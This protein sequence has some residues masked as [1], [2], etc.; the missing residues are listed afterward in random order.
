[1]DARA[2]LVIGCFRAG[3][4]DR[5]LFGF[6]LQ[7]VFLDAWQFDDRQ[8]VV[9]LLEHIDRRKWSPAGRRVAEPLTRQVRIKRPL[10]VEQWVEWIG[11]RGDH[12]RTL[13]AVG[14][15]R[16]FAPNGTGHRPSAERFGIRFGSVKWGVPGKNDTRPDVGKLLPGKRFIGLG[17]REGAHSLPQFPSSIGLRQERAGVDSVCIPSAAGRP[18]VYR[19]GVPGRAWLTVVPMVIPPSC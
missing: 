14:R 3:D 2:V 4:S 19:T 18:L 11:K 8:N 17:I 1:M 16:D 5:V 10:Q 7:L 15:G 6:D 13:A 9:A 12:G